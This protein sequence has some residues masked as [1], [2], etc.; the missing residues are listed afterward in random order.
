[1]SPMINP[2]STQIQKV[3]IVISS[4]QDPDRIARAVIDRLSATDGSQI[5]IEHLEIALSQPSATPDLVNA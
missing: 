3:E 1:M 5:H 2:S 4:N